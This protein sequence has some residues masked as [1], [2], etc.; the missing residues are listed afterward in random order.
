MYVCMYVCI[1]TCVCAFNT[2]YSLF[3][4]RSNTA[5]LPS[6]KTKTQK[7]THVFQDTIMEAGS[8]GIASGRNRRGETDGIID[9]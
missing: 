9:M 1:C 7:K 4:T 6:Q 8:R 3:I 5:S 2:S